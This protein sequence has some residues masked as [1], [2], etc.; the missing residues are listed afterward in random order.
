MYKKITGTFLALFAGMAIA[1]LY[2][3]FSET[4]GNVTW[5]DSIYHQNVSCPKHGQVEIPPE[6]L[7]ENKARHLA[8]CARIYHQNVS[9]PRHGQVEIP[10]EVLAEKKARHVAWCD[11]INHRNVGCPRHVQVEEVLVEK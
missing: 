10:P 11:S 1:V 9:C 5:C 2:S 6:V 8:W 4:E 3:D 7:A